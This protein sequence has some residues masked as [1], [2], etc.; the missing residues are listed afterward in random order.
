MQHMFYTNRNQKCVGIAM[1]L[2]KTSVWKEKEKV[3]LYWTRRYDHG[4][5]E[6]SNFVKQKLLDLIK[7]MWTLK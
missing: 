3:T 6:A 4:K 7:K 5:H 1:L 2:N